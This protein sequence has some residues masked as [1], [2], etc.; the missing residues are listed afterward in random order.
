MRS[1][2]VTSVGYLREAARSLGDGSAFRSLELGT[3]HWPLQA[4]LSGSIIKAPGFA[5]G[6]LPWEAQLVIGLRLM[7]LAAGGPRR[8]SEARRL[9]PEKTETLAEAGAAAPSVAMPS[10]LNEL[11][12]QKVGVRSLRASCAQQA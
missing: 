5:G 4:A 9:V 7:R 8:E 6:Y 3:C 2:A 12:R 1:F 11:S 10:P